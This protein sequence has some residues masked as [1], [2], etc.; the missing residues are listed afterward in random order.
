MIISSGIIIRVTP[1]WS[2]FRVCVAE[3]SAIAAQTFQL[4][5]R[6]SGPALDA[7]APTYVSWLGCTQAL[8]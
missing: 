4:R 8:R 7:A 2:L 3:C 1:L 5:S 6:L